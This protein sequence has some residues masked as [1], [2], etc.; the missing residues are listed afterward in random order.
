MLTPV[1][2]IYIAMNIDVLMFDLTI[3]RNQKK[4]T[5]TRMQTAVMPFF[6]SKEKGISV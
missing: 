4:N 1:P 3:I 5:M 2:L 6:I